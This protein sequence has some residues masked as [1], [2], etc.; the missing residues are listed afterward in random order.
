[1]ASTQ[2]AD[3]IVPEVFDRAVQ[4]E[5][6]E[7]TAIIESGAMVDDAEINTKLANG[8]QTFNISSF[9]D[10]ENIDEN[11]SN[12][13]EP[14]KY[15]TGVPTDDSIPNKIIMGNE[16]VV[17]LSRNQSW[18]ASNLT[19][20]LSGADPMAA[21][22]NRVAKY[23]AR[24]LQ[25]AVIATVKGVFADNAAAPT[26][27]EHIQ[28]DM[29]HDISGAA[30]VDGTTT[31]SGR[32]ALAAMLT[33]GDAQ[34]SLSMI[35]VHSIVYHRMQANNLITFREHSNGLIQIPLFLGRVVIV[36]DAMPTDGAGIFESWLFGAGALRFGSHAPDHATEVSRHPDAGNGAGSDVLH[37]R[38]GWAIAPTGMAYVGNTTAQGGPDNTATASNLAHQDS[39]KRVYP[40][41]KQIKIARLITREF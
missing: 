39:W 23:R 16:I 4:Q 22:S 36:D 14:D 3:V 28:D 29:T 12:D 7:L 24:R 32:A 31:F 20:E 37:T 38:W 19:K 41:R 1:M 33:M 34:E 6:M 13:I 5:T 15:T 25:G 30:F 35:M 9:E 11:I 26:G 18:Q 40:E 21:I 8:G 2:L 17:R 10:L 27:A